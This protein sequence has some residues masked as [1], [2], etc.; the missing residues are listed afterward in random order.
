MNRELRRPFHVVGIFFSESLWRKL[1]AP[2]SVL[3]K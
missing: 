1:L 3:H 2:T